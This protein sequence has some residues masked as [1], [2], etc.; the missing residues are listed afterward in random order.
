MKNDSEFINKSSLEIIQELEKIATFLDANGHYDD[1]DAIDTVITRIAKEP[2]THTDSS[3]VVWTKIG[4]VPMPRG[5]IEWSDTRGNK[6]RVEPGKL[7]YSAELKVREPMKPKPVIVKKDEVETEKVKR[8][9][10]GGLVGWIEKNLLEPGF[11][12]K[13]LDKAMDPIGKEDGDVNN[14]GKEDGSDEYLMN[15]RKK[16]EESKR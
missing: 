3:G 1:A 10:P 12:V 11:G 9:D 13:K 7:P 2:E 4:P 6:M 15:R 16:I 5:Y 8:P 14:D